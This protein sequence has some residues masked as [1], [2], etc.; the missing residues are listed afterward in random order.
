MGAD[1]MPGFS[2]EYVI[3]TNMEVCIM[4]DNK[5]EADRLFNALGDG[6]SIAMP[7]EDQFWGDYFG[8]VKDKYNVTWMILCSGK[9]QS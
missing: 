3:G 7:M 2:P 6:G 5:S 1:M 4:T 8:S 9:Q